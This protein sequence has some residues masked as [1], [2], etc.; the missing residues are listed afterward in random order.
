ME[1]ASLLLALWLLLPAEAAAQNGAPAE[2]PD[3]IVVTG[4][5]PGPPLWRVAAGDHVLWIFPQLSPVPKGMVW[6]SN[7]VAAVIADAQEA[8]ELP[9]FGADVSPRLYLNPLNLI[10][11]MRLAK[12][13]SRDTSGKTLEEL[14]P[15]DVYSRFEAL[16]AKYFPKDAAELEELRP[17]F[18]AGRMVGKVESKEGLV[19]DEGIMKTIDRMIRRNRGLERTKI[20]VKVDLEG[21]FGAL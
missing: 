14:L 13:L 2:T 10:R 15:P 19:G 1:W 5:Q 11:G 4:R 7:R 9:G 12:R 6:Q 18:A 17:A 21:G 3:E 8:L 16:E 20:E